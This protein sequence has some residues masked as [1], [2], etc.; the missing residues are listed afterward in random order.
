MRRLFSAGLLGLQVILWG[1]AFELLRAESAAATGESL[2]VEPGSASD[3]KPAI[4]PDVARSAQALTAV[5]PVAGHVVRMA[6]IIPTNRTAQAHAVASLR[7]V[8]LHYQSWYREQMEVNGF[9]SKTFRYETEPDGVTPKVYTIRV[10]ATDAFLRADLW[11]RTISAASG[12]GVP[13][14]T[15][16]QVWWLIPEAHLQMADGSIVGGTA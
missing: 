12:A 2:W 15:A 3:I 8:I 14:W 10:T 6:Y 1:S 13:V 11:N 9:G 4:K 5:D 7:N 16:K